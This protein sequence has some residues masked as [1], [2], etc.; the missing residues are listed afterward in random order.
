MIEPPATSSYR[1]LLFRVVVICLIPIATRLEQ[2]GVLS[3]SFLLMVIRLDVFCLVCQYISACKLSCNLSLLS[4]EC[5][6]VL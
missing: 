3:P 4:A 2:H 1:A 6:C 5:H